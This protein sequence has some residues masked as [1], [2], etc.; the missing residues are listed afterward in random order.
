MYENNPLELKDIYNVQELKQIKKKWLKVPLGL[1]DSEL[2]EYFITG[3]DPRLKEP[4]K[5]LIFNPEDKKLPPS[6][7]KKEPLWKRAIKIFPGKQSNLPVKT[8]DV[9]DQV[10]QASTQPVNVDQ[11][12]GL[13]RVEDALLSNEEK[14]I[15]LRNKG[16]TV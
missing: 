11:K 10:L 5:E 14:A 4:A 15:K 8:T 2:E 1:S 16:V 12:T 9:S 13:T 6:G 7:D 3:E